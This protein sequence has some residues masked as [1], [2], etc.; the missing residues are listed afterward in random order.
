[1]HSNPLSPI[2]CGGRSRC[3]WIWALS[4]CTLPELQTRRR[5]SEKRWKETSD[6]SGHLWEFHTRSSRR[7]KAHVLG[8]NQFL[9]RRSSHYAWVL[10]VLFPLVFVSF[11][12]LLL[13]MDSSKF[14]ILSL[15]GFFLF[16]LARETL[17]TTEGS[18]SVASPQ[19]RL[20]DGEGRSLSSWLKIQ[21]LSLARSTNFC[22]W[23]WF[24]FLLMLREVS[25]GFWICRGEDSGLFCSLPCRLL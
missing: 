7:P 25:K 14:L 9:K 4:G 24:T 11:S 15:A 13:F 12:G 19:G 21:A 8:G 5:P 23:L 3:R 1:M 20:L 10:T 18:S 6:D 16:F 17:F 22:S 2:P